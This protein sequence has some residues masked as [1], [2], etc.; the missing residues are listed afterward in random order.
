MAAHSTLS[1]TSDDTSVRALPVTAR[2]ARANSLRRA[3][4]ID[5]N[6]QATLEIIMSPVASSLVFL[7]MAAVL[8]A[9]AASVALAND[10]RQG[11]ASTEAS[12]AFGSGRY[13]PRPGEMRSGFID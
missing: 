13:M 9:G 3:H 6:H 12:R 5:P 11:L 2:N 8:V 1:L 4:L 10:S 7:A